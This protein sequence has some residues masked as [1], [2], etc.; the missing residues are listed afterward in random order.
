ML[1]ASTVTEEGMGDAKD[2][3]LV[4]TTSTATAPA[5]AVSTDQF[6]ETDC[7][8]SVLDTMDRC[9]G[10][11]EGVEVQ[12]AFEEQLGQHEFIDWHSSEPH[13]SLTSTEAALIRLQIMESKEKTTQLPDLLNICGGEEKLSSKDAADTTMD[14]VELDLSFQSEAPPNDEVTLQCA[15]CEDHAPAS[16]KRISFAKLPCC[17]ETS[18]H[19][20]AACI[21]VLSFPTTDGSSRVGRCPHCRSWIRVEPPASAAVSTALVMRSI[22]NQGGP[23]GVCGRHKRC[24]LEPELCD[25]CFIGRRQP[26][27]YECEQCHLTQRIPHP[28]YRYQAQPNAFGNVTWNCEGSC[29]NF[30]HWRLLEDQVSLV[31]VGDEPTSWGL[32]YRQS[33]KARV[34]QT[35]RELSRDDPLRDCHENGCSIL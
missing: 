7:H 10:C 17:S 12:Q 33:A 11:V 24:L 27:L 16:G 26:L 35:R 2:H 31:P 18:L 14:T 32:D 34:L 4:A 29:G 3:R 30:T 15:V 5:T 6:H 28:M 20:C 25:A 21:L 9:V 19:M 22:S 1:A 13:Q 8:S 23:C